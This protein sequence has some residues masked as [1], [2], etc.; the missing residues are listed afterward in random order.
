MVTISKRKLSHQVLDRLIAAIGSK[1]YP[2]GT[3]LP[4]E[5]ELM[6]RYGV[7]RPAVRE[8]LQKLEQMGLIIISHGE[9]A[10]VIAPSPS[11]I[12]DQVS[13]AM[14]HLLATSPHGLDDLKEARLLFETGLV[15]VAT[16][17]ATSE[18]LAALHRA[19]I[20]CHEA[21]GDTQRFIAA[22]MAFHRLIAAMLGNRF[23]EAVSQNLLDW[24]MRFR[25]DFV[26]VRG[27]ERLTLDEHERIYRAIAA[28]DSGAAAKAMTEHLTRANKL[29]SVLAGSE[30]RGG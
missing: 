27:A 28:G 25:R 18:S 17:R 30:P 14:L 15:R 10:R 26:S 20:E 9:R 29:Y 22:D 1:E 5:R 16:E 4:S 12:I 19:L 6:T 23:I 21:R 7:G 8:A 24:L 3:Q 2:P 11:S 13:G